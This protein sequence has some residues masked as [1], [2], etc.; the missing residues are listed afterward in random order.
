M[1]ASY[2]IAAAVGSKAAGVVV[3]TATEFLSLYRAFLRESN[4]FSNYNFRHFVRR[5]ARE[6]FEKNIAVE[7]PAEAFEFGLKQLLIC[8]RQSLLSSLY[9]PSLKS[10]IEIK[11]NR[12]LS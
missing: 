12:I 6:E 9:Q 8:K 2:S 7:N 3:P 1:A 10:V 5:R 4:R 11:S